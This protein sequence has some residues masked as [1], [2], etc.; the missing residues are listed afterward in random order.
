MGPKGVRGFI[1]IPGVFG[2]P[3]PDGERGIP[4]VHGK[5]GKMGRPG[6]AGDFGERGPPGPDGNPVSE[7]AEMT[8]PLAITSDLCSESIFLFQILTLCSIELNWRN[9]T[10]GIVP[11][12]Q[13][14]SFWHS[15]QA[16]SNA[17]G[18]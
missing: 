13:S 18:I 9:G 2:L 1:G 5:K 17:Q 3:G 7:T 6:F 4:G 8:V 12:V 15:R 11:K 10:N 14:S 16:Q